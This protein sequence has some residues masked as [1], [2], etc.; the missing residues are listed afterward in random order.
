MLGY[1]WAVT[2]NLVAT[3]VVLAMFGHASGPFETM[4]IAGLTL[5]YLS[6]I[7]VSGVISRIQIQAILISN[8]QFLKIARH[9]NDPEADKYSDQFEEATKDF[10]TVTT[11]FYISCTFSFLLCAIAIFKIFSVL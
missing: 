11:R 9:I 7:Y 2:T 1:V 10:K 5:I 3:A 8:K 4:V 6:I